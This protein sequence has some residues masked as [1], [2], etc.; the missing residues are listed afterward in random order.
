MRLVAVGKGM[1]GWVAA[2]FQ[3]Y[4]RRLPP[5]LVL[6]LVEVAAAHRG[7]S[8]HAGRA[9]ED[10]GERLLAAVPRGATLVALDERGEGWSTRDLAARLARWM[11][12]GAEPVLLVGGPDG[13]APACVARAQR[14]WSLSPLT[15]PHMLVRVLVAEQVYRAW[16]LLCGHPYHRP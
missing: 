10:E 6:D 1:P 3:E 15:L 4:A 2:G 7:P 14:L 9:R 11:E 5:Q 13:L 12:D 8:G 16:T